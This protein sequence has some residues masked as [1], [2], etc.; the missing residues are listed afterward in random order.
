MATF[1]E[2]C[3][4]FVLEMSINGGRGFTAISDTNVKFA[5]AANYIKLANTAL[6][7]LHLDWKFLW[8]RHS[9]ALTVGNRVVP[10]PAGINVRHWVRDSFWLERGNASQLRLRYIPFEE[11]ERMPQRSNSRKPS[12]FTVMPNNSVELDNLPD[13]AY[14]LS[15]NY[16]RRHTPFTADDDVSPIPEEYH[17]IILL[18]AKLLYA[19]ME[20]A[21]EITNGSLA[22]YSELIEVLQNEQWAGMG[23]AGYDSEHMRVI[24]E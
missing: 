19:E 5:K 11:W 1:K 13:T 14:Q 16:Y 3:E 21:P 15:A 18:R 7:T 6:C 17:R 22:E 9:V 4:S 23:G 10:G 24:T 12:S 8:G 2:L 20:D